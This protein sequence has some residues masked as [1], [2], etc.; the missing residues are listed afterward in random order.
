MY[1][2]DSMLDEAAGTFVVCATAALPG[3]GLHP[4]ARG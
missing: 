2:A 3:L 4:G 1:L